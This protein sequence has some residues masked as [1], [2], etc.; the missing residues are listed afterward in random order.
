MNLIFEFKSDKTNKQRISVIITGGLT[1][2]TRK[3]YMI[4]VT[5]LLNGHIHKQFYVKCLNYDIW[6]R[7]DV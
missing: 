5:L 3:I 1:T 2:P 6:Y 4:T 7:L